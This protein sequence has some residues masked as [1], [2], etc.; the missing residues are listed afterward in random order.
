MSNQK[1]N[2][3][4]RK[5][6][7]AVALVA[8]ATD[9]LTTTFVTTYLS[10][11]YTEFLMVTA[12]AVGAILGFGILVDGVSDFLMGMV[13]DR[14][15]TKY[16]KARHWFLWM[17]IPAFISTALLFFCPKNMPMAGKVA[18][19]FIVYNVFCTCLTTVRL[20]AQSIIS[21][22][23]EHGTAR[24]TASLIHGFTSQ[25]GNA[26]SSVLF[27]PFLAA[28]GGGILA[29]RSASVLFPG[30]AG[31]FMLTAFF[32]LREMRTSG[33]T[34]NQNAAEETVSAES[35]AKEKK[36]SS[37]KAW[38]YL[39]KNKYWVLTEL[40]EICMAISVGFMIGTATYF[41]KYVL[42][43]VGAV[44]GVFGVMSIGMLLGIIICAPI[45]RKV[46]SRIIAMVGNFIACAGFCVAA[47]GVL[48]LKQ[49][50]FLYA[51]I[52]IKQIGSGLY[53]GVSMGLVA[54]VIDYG[55]WKFGIR[56]DGL[57][58]S[59][60]LVMRKIASAAASAIL[61]F[62]LTMSG[63]VGGMDVVSDQVVFV[64]KLLFLVIPAVS[65]FFAGIFYAMFNL[66]DKRMVQIQKDLEERK[67]T[68]A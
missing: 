34:E 67:G 41:C 14:V 47:F 59:G 8:L 9:G 36:V 22:C 43:D 19:L 16:G 35:K 1:L 68:R 21:L 25:L 31:I 27:A 3:Q 64:L 26:I 66:S 10:Y 52:V 23:F 11:Y 12:A 63:Y 60:K 30:I 45:V 13:V 17:A 20:P 18:Y 39:F 46:D 37:L 15:E 5:N 57:A 7:V 62:V 49:N 28:L 51:G 54:R 4:D 2:K 40:A 32:L 6:L 42:G 58:Y 33:K 55:E 53:Y 24:E 56:Q 29:Y 61:G 38:I 48:V 50:V 44:G 65:L